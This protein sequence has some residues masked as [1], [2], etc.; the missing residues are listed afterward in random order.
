MNHTPFII[1]AFAI[2]IAGM[3]WLIISSYVAMRRAEDLAKDVSARSDRD[4][5]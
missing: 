1:A 2:T 5:G 3:G 4:A